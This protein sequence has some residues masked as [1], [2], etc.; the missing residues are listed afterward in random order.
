MRL[1]AVVCCFCSG[2]LMAAEPPND[3]GT[4]F[5]PSNENRVSEFSPPELFGPSSK[6][7]SSQTFRRLTRSR[8]SGVRPRKPV[9]R[10][11]RISR[12]VPAPLDIYSADQQGVKQI[13]A[14][15]QTA[16]PTTGALSFYS[17]DWA[18]D[19]AD[20]KRRAFSERRPIFFIMVT[21]YSGPADFFSGH[22]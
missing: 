22:C 17:L 15:F 2:L 20:A 14:E 13:L 12:P 8:R 18:E 1:S 16:L 11:P 3:H 4:L 10:S 9:R 7:R 6:Q 19:L 21:N 5:D